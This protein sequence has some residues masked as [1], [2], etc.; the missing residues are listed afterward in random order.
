MDANH[1]FLQN[2]Y[3]ESGYFEYDSTQNFAHLNPDGTFTVYDQ[4]GAITGDAEHKTTREHG[5]FMPY[6]DISPDK[7][8]AYD[9]DGHI[10]TNQTDVLAH[11]LPDTNARRE[12]LYL[13]GNNKKG[14][15]IQLE[16][17][18]I[19]SSGWAGSKLH[20]G[21]EWSDLGP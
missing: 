13:I 1:L 8:Y 19:T 6:N 14:M 11:E 15:R 16:T 4:L 2:I 10:I 3:N 5:Q 20:T 17:V 7:G 21:A 12:N 18:S 9:K